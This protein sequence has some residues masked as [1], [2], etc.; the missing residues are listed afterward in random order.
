MYHYPNGK[1]NDYNTKAM[2]TILNGLS[3]SNSHKVICW[4]RENEICNKLQFI[5]DE[6]SHMEFE[7]KKYS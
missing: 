4:E 1:K 6:D 7:V 5:Y 2:K 3:K